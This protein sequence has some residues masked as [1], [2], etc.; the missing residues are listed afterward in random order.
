[1]LLP[2]AYGRR[3]RECDPDNALDAH[4]ARRSWDYPLPL[5]V[6]TRG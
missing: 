3:A 1:V 2:L 5:R 6:D 4:Q